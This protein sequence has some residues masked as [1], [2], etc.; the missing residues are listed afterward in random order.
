MIDG[1][2]GTSEGLGDKLFEVGNRE[3]GGRGKKEEEVE[4]HQAEPGPSPPGF[5]GG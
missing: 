4:G 3:S 2:V 5:G 1:R